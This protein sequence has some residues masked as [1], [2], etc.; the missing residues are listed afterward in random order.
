MFE[1][2]PQK[3]TRNPVW[4]DASFIIPI[5]DPEGGIEISVLDSNRGKSF[6][7]RVL[8]PIAAI[9]TTL[10]STTSLDAADSMAAQY[11]TLHKTF[12]LIG[13][14]GFKGESVSGD[15][16]VRLRWIRIQPAMAASSARH[17]RSEL[18]RRSSST[19]SSVSVGAIGGP[20]ED[21]ETPM[22]GSLPPVDDW[23]ARLFGKASKVSTVPGPGFSLE[24]P[25]VSHAWQLPETEINV[26]D[27]FRPEMNWY[28]RLF[29]PAPHTNYVG[30][31]DSLGDSVVVVSVLV[32]DSPSSPTDRVVYWT[33]VWR[34]EA[35]VKFHVTRDAH[36][37]SYTLADLLVDGG[38]SDLA[39]KVK[40]LHPMSGSSNPG[41]VEALLG[42]EDPEDGN[43][44]KVGVLLATEGQVEENEMFGNR[45][46]SPNFAEFLDLLGTQVRLAGY[47]GY[48]A[49]L[50]VN[51]DKSGLY[52]V[53]TTLG[54]TEIMFHVS[55]HLQYDPTD[56]QYIQRKRFIGNDIVVIVFA[57]GETTEFPVSSL[58][59]QY[60][61]V[62]AIVRP[63]QDGYRVDFA[64]KRGL[65]PFDPPH[66]L[67]YPREP[68]F[69]TSLLTKCLNGEAATVASPEFQIR[70]RRTRKQYLELAAGDHF[71]DAVVGCKYKAKSKAEKSLGLHLLPNVPQVPLSALSCAETQAHAQREIVPP[72]VP[73]SGAWDGSSSISSLAPFGDDCMMYGSNDGLFFLPDSFVA[74]DSRPFPLA[75]QGSAVAQIGTLGGPG[76]PCSTVLVLTDGSSPQLFSLQGS[77][78]TECLADMNAWAADRVG[79]EGRGFEPSS[80]LSV[81]IIPFTQGANV[82]AA[83]YL[84]GA[85]AAERGYPIV[86]VAVGSVLD[87]LR[88]KS[89]PDQPLQLERALALPLSD[90]A[91]CLLVTETGIV[92]GVGSDFVFFPLTAG[93]VSDLDTAR[94]EIGVFPKVVLEA[95][96]PAVPGHASRPETDPVPIAA[97]ELLDGLLLCFDQYGVV[98]LAETLHLDPSRPFVWRG[99]PL[100]FRVCRH[101]IY[102]F[103]VYE[104]F[105]E[106]RSM[107]NGSLIESFLIPSY[108]PVLSSPG[109]TLDFGTAS[110]SIIRLV[111]KDCGSGGF[112]V[113][114]G[115]DKA[116][117]RRLTMTKAD[118]L[119]AI[120]A[121]LS[122]DAAPSS[123]KLSIGSKRVRRVSK[124]GKRRKSLVQTL[125][126]RRVAAKRRQIRTRRKAFRTSRD[127]D[128]D[129]D[130][131]DDDDG[132]DGDGDGEGGWEG[133]GDDGDMSSNLNESSSLLGI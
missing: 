111:P 2:S 93:M 32:T 19:L 41:L 67:V 21:D 65:R 28:S 78:I 95:E 123:T 46:P 49:Q 112:E 34:R 62:L 12:P 1:S 57:D 94:P 13:L 82:F 22:L 131:G 23:A 113:P 85:H 16:E 116:S 88:V 103:V 6:L 38:F 117:G 25:S 102:L 43:T 26:R 105:V 83:G 9:P 31:H 125:A 115:M 59:S 107:T 97:F 37:N 126:A 42:V 64:R 76:E 108:T 106:V 15:L 63:V 133:E 99:Q 29:A 121:F 132:D 3:K 58:T 120:D 20:D 18:A 118:A 109:S 90:R 53:A 75:L 69:I 30:W 73:G 84:G 55:T 74:T 87:V 77:E 86:A 48:A 4:E 60:T 56:E 72:F 130:D 45:D 71:G 5:S 122:E 40:Y 89:E 96:P 100:S 98:V 11:S 101:N 10:K 33:I 110:G 119:A 79:R 68:G 124:G 92:A 17:F 8:L 39:D 80:S 128:D 47:S 35:I 127:D 36:N 70:D 104:A 50:D 24:L 129:D 51:Y 114:E 61:N 66:A 52:S 7:G 27:D 44:W 54:Q 91:S 14:S 81:G